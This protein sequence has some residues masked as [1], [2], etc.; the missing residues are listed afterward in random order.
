[1]KKL[2]KWCIQKI[3]NWDTTVHPETMQDVMYL[4][5]HADERETVTALGAV[6]LLGCTRPTLR[7]YVK[8]GWI[9]EVYITKSNRMYDKKDIE[10]LLQYGQP[11]PKV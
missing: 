6:R 7:R 2:T 5:D 3:L 1:M 9:R 10:R 11:P 4:L 8:N